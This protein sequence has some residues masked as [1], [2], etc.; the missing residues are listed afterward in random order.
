MRGR[1]SLA[2]HLVG[3][4]VVAQFLAFMIAWAI[5]LG[6]GIA[7]IW[8]FDLSLDT[9][10]TSRIRDLVIASLVRDADHGIRIEPSPELLAESRRTSALKYAAFDAMTYEPLPGSSPELAKALTSVI[11]INSPHTHFVL[12]EDPKSTPKGY[13]APISTPFGPLQ[14]AV[15]G[16]RFRLDDIYYAMVDSFQWSAVEI[17]TAIAVTAALAWLAVRRGLYPLRAL[18]DEATRIN[19]DSLDQRLSTNNVPAEVAPLVSAINNALARLDQSAMRLRRYTANAAHELRTPLAIMRARLEDAEE[20]TFKTDLMRD[21]S[22]L[23]AIVEQMLIAARLTENQVAIDQEMDLVKVIRE[24][25]SRRLPLAVKCDRAIEFEALG[26]PVVTRGNRRAVECAVAN[27]IDNA[28][29]AEP[30]GGTVLVR[31]REDAVF[32]VIDHGEGVPFSDRDMIFEPFWRK[33]DVTPGTGLGLAITKELID[34]NNGRIWVEDTE[35]GGATFIVSFSNAEAG[36][37]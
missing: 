14:I 17:F 8:I 15:Y 30:V 32:E 11:R 10:A 18:S 34:K 27:L 37:C 35:G 28:L 5:T 22:Q 36:T 19:M 4:L 1:A 12:P 33:S 26:S 16:S 13:A 31:V 25:V 2:L 6:L 23:Q 20:P 29:R 9:L 3:Y 21:A 24:I 7:H